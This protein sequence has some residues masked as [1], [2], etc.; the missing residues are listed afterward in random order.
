LFIDLGLSYNNN[1]T[2]IGAIDNSAWS[3]ER[4]KT[5][6]FLNIKKFI[7]EKFSAS[8]ILTLSGKVDTSNNAVVATGT[9]GVNLEYNKD[10]NNTN[11]IFAGLAAYYQ[12]GTDMVRGYEGNYKNISAYLVS[13]EFGL[14]TME[15]RLEIATGMEMISGHNYSNDN[16]EYNNTRH[17]F[18]LLYSARFPYYGGHINYFII[19]DSYKIGTKGG[20]YFDPH[21]RL[22]YKLNKKSII[23]FWFYNPMLTTDVRAYTTIDQITKKP[24]GTEFDENGNPVY[25][26]GS[27]GYH[28]DLELTH[29][30]SK[31]V[32]LKLGFSYAIPSDIKNQMVYGYKNLAEKQL[33]ELGQNYFGWVMLIVKPQFYNKS[34]VCL[35]ND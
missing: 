20:G 1:G 32:I 30:F 31:E 35:L 33:Y 22:K 7:G 29:K 12:H 2:R 21:I 5:M 17:S 27:L 6:N 13:A 19:Q 18:D 3:E 4:I 11:G 16:D 26:K 23:D 15:E 9:H 8:L 25:W 24:T 14:R 34:K 28:I 10:R